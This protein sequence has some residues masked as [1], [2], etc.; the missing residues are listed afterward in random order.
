VLT[1]KQLAGMSKDGLIHHG[2][3]MEALAVS[4]GSTLVDMCNEARE[5]AKRIEEL[6]AALEKVDLD[7]VAAEFNVVDV[8]VREKKLLLVVESPEASGEERT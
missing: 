7:V 4:A 2:Q 1:E 6:E 3:V 5:Q 8:K